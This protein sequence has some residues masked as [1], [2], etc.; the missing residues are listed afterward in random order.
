[1]QRFQK[2][3][4]LSLIWALSTRG[5]LSAQIPLKPEDTVVCYGN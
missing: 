4:F 2:L 5:P 1:M 3:L